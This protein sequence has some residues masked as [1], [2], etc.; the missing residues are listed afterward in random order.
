MRY[1]ENDWNKMMSAPT[2]I[3]D[4]EDVEHPHPR[5]IINQ[6]G[7]EVYME[8]DRV[9][10]KFDPLYMGEFRYRHKSFKDEGSEYPEEWP[11][12]LVFKFIGTQKNYKHV[13]PKYTSLLRWVD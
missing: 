12:W 4:L 6:D 5:R 8:G 11:E 13:R 2:Y 1:N 3:D 10:W 9:V 7:W